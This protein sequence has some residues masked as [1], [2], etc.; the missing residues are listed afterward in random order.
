MRFLFIYWSLVDFWGLLK[1]EKHQDENG[2]IDPTEIKKGSKDP[3]C[4]D[5]T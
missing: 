4:K 3:G 5:G 2:K 1:W